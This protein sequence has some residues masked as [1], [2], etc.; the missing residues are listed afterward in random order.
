[1]WR[2]TGMTKETG[3][4]TIVITENRANVS[5]YTLEYFAD[6]KWHAIAE[7]I[8]TSRIKVH[9]LTGCMEKKCALSLTLSAVHRPLQYNERR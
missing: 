9:A 1:M 6:N 4:K 8:N 3:F 7:G 2:L 5:A